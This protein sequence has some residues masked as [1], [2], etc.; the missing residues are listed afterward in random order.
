MRRSRRQ[1]SERRR[2]SALAALFALLLQAFLIQTHVHAPSLAFA[3][4]S[5][6]VAD[7]AEADAIEAE[8]ASCTLC[9]MLRAGGATLPPASGSPSVEPASAGVGAVGHAPAPQAPAHDW[10]SRAP[11]SLL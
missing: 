5:Q 2:A 4:Q 9:D 6:T 1:R 7:F 11:P 10:R 8:R 3:A